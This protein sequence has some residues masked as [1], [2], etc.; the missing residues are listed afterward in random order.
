M[1]ET[2]ALGKLLT[3]HAKQVKH[4][5][6]ARAT[7][8]QI[9][10]YQYEHAKQTDSAEAD[11]L[12]MEIQD[13]HQDLKSADKSVLNLIVSHDSP[14]HELFPTLENTHRPPRKTRHP[15]RA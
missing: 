2:K 3:D 6:E 1:A 7:Q 4:E 14:N 5:V 12:R 13:L 9:P 10:R 15:Q 11:Q 8:L